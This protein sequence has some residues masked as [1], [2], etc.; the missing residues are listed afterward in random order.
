MCLYIC[1]Q[2]QEPFHL[3]FMSD[4][5]TEQF[6]LGFRRFETRHGKRKEIISDN[7]SQMK[8]VTDV[9]YKLWRQILSENDH[10]YN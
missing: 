4:M 1:L 6:L 5:S 7:A 8:L 2:L 3:E 10:C 9:I